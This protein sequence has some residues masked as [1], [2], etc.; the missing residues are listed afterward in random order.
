ML[1]ARNRPRIGI[2]IKRFDPK[3]MPDPRP[4]DP[5]LGDFGARE[6]CVHVVAETLSD[7]TDEKMF[8]ADVVGAKATAQLGGVV[9]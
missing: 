1:F 2:R 5:S 7:Q 6:P 9:E 8:G 3:E 4:K